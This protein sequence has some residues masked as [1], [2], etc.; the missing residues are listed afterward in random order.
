M[1]VH[2]NKYTSDNFCNSFFNNPITSLFLTISWP[3][4]PH[5]SPFL[6]FQ[7]CHDKLF[8]NNT[9]RGK[10]DHHENRK[11]NP[12]DDPEDAEN[13]EARYVPIHRGTTKHGFKFFANLLI[14]LPL[15]ILAERYYAPF[16]L[17]NPVRVNCCLQL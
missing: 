1:C 7:N 6:V 17:K 14:K 2:R 15:S 12:D 9:R 13:R 5:L 3:A 11:V 16:L 8:E 10:K 4:A